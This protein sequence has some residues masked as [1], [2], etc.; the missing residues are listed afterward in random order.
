MVWSIAS[1]QG[2]N[3]R[4]SLRLIPEADLWL[5][6]PASSAQDSGTFSHLS[7]GLLCYF[8][9]IIGFVYASGSV[10]CRLHS[11]LPSGWQ[12]EYVLCPE[13][14]QRQGVLAEGQ[15]AHRASG[16]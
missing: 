9:S 3:L 15:R 1:L 5:A 6:R 12:G 16:A 11:D 7:F 4:S 2:A 10:P 8:G 13:I 14:G